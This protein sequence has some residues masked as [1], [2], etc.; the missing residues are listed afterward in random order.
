MH[1]ILAKILNLLAVDH[2]PCP[3]FGRGCEDH[4]AFGKMLFNDPLF[5]VGSKIG[6]GHIEATAQD[7]VG[8]HCP[9]VEAHCQADMLT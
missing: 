2:D 4:A 5:D 3:V 6:V 1:A 7:V 9:V 8:F